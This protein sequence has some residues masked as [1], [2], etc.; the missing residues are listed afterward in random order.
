M[1]DADL[2][3]EV[4]DE[5]IEQLQAERETERRRIADL[6]RQLADARTDLAETEKAIGGW[7]AEVRREMGREEA[8]TLPASASPR[9]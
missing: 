1:S 7:L 5:H 2:L 9:T 6:E 4:S 3:A 8:C